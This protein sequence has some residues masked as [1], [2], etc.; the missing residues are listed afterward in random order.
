MV[1]TFEKGKLVTRGH[2]CVYN[3]VRAACARLES[4]GLRPGMLVGILAG[5]CYEWIV[6]DL[7]LLE[8]QALS[9]AFTDDFAGMSSDQLIDRYSLSL[10]LVPVSEKERKNARQS[11]AVAF[12]DGEN[13]SIN[14]IPR[15]QPQRIGSL[16]QLVW[17]FPPD[18][19]AD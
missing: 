18:H 10:L 14:A 4:W 13:S 12:L 5:N 16:R 6:Y 15:E 1:R 11:E 19:P 9:V 2:D 3:D 7:A 8:M 17:S